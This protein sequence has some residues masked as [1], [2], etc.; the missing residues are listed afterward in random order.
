MLS[1]DQFK[2]NEVWIAFRI[3][4]TF[5]FVKD[6]PYDIYALIDAAS[7]YIFGNV[8]T[9]VTDEIPEQEDVD[10]LFQDAWAAK[11]QWARKLI[12]P[13]HDPAEKVFR[14]QAEKNGLCFE[15]VPLSE[16]LPMV[17]FMKESFS[18]KFG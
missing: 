1:Y 5:M 13:E 4:E 10:T 17:E 6:E 3:N 7:T 9:K 11:K 16:L 14:T 12:F 8:L 2:I 15:T 18:S